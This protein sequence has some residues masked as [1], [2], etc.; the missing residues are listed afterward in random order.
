MAKETTSSDFETV[1]KE[2]AERYNLVA[3]TLRVAVR[4][5]LTALVAKRIAEQIV[6]GKVAPPKKLKGG[7]V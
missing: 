4:T 3:H 1:L 5:E 2:E 6:E 7:V